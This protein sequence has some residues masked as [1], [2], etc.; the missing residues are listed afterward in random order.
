MP[1]Y[2]SAKVDWVFNMEGSARKN[3]DLDVEMLPYSHSDLSLLLKV[4][5]MPIQAFMDIECTI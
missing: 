4:A 3:L 1:R 5:K 2:S